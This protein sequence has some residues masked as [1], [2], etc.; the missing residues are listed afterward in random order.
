[1]KNVFRVVYIAEKSD[2][3][4]KFIRRVGMQSRYGR[5]VLANSILNNDPCLLYSVITLGNVLEKNEHSRSRKAP[6]S[7]GNH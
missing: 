5:D 4:R 6:I 1:M 2:R 3:W 7:T